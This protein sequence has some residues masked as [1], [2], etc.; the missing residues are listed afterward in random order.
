MLKKRRVQGHGKWGMFNS[1]YRRPGENHFP[2]VTLRMA[3]YIW[4]ATG[5]CIELYSFYRT[6]YPH[7]TLFFLSTQYY[8]NLHVLDVET[9]VHYNWM[10]YPAYLFFKNFILRLS[11]PPFPHSWS[12]LWDSVFFFV[13]LAYYFPTYS[14]LFLP[15]LL[16]VSLCEKVY[17]VRP[18]FHSPK[19]ILST[20]FSTWLRWC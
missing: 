5:T 9:E 4:I 3:V 20:C 8:Y 12:L 18:L 14:M 10:T 1:F 2:Q 11:F 7:L 17:S 16:S 6:F 13:S 19:W 15:F